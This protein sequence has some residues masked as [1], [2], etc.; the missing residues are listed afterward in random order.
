M[1][2]TKMVEANKL[3]VVKKAMFAGLCGPSGVGKSYCAGTL[4]GRTI[5]LHS[6]SESHGVASA[7]AS[8]R[9]EIIP[10][11]WEYDDAFNHLEPSQQYANLLAFLKQ[12]DKLAKIGDNLVL[13]SAT[14][15]EVLIR[16]SKEFA[17]KITANT[18]KAKETMMYGDWTIDLLRPIFA[19]L[20]ELNQKYG[21]NIFVI[22][23]TKDIVRD[24]ELGTYET[25]LVFQG[26]KVN[27]FFSQQFHQNFLITKRD[28]KWKFS[29]ESL[30]AK[31]MKDLKGVSTGTVN[32]LN[33]IR[34]VSGAYPKTVTADLEIVRKWF[35]DGKISKPEA[36]VVS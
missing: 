9:A 25:Q 1:D 5:Y 20:S 11:C 34:G 22:V 32:F 31:D 29:F 3:K 36:E 15:G 27:D 14:M 13:D 8:G 12:G 16:A 28:G 17:A 6:G 35:L 23:H 7:K 18:N 26:Y 4:K 2:I 19:A 10:I 21:I 24:A 33:G 30:I